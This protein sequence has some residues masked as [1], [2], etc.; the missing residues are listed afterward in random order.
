ME[1]TIQQ[2]GQRRSSHVKGYYPSTMDTMAFN[3]EVRV[4]ERAFHRRGSILEP[5]EKNSRH[6]E[7]YSCCE[8]QT[9]SSRVDL[10]RRL[11]VSS[12]TLCVIFS[13]KCNSK[14]PSFGPPMGPPL[15]PRGALLWLM[16][17]SLAD[18]HR[19]ARPHT[20][21]M[22]HLNDKTNELRALRFGQSCPTIDRS[23]Y[24]NRLLYR[25]FQSR[26][27]EK[28]SYQNLTAPLADWSD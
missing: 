27:R 26:A 6:N 9:L 21:C 18:Y 11:R 23:A 19:I 24:D 10:P 7:G 4:V 8:A 1:I 25:A 17:S 14:G 20:C 5:L 12:R 2:H 22:H 28:P 16:A 3:M 13:W 15:G